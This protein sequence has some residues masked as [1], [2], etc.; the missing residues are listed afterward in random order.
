MGKRVQ[1]NALA[2]ILGVVVG[3][4]LWGIPGTFMA[5]PILAILKV[6]FEEIEPMQ[7]FA[8]LMGDDDEEKSLSKPVL[9]RIARTVSRKRKPKE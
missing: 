8:L 5:V 7:P 1:M 6:S 4:A 2:T 9:R 3:S